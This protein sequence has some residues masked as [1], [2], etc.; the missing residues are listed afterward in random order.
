[1]DTLNHI[2]FVEFRPMLNLKTIATEV[3]MFYTHLDMLI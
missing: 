1:M 3:K 2:L